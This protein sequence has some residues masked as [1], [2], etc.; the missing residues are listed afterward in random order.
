MVGVMA[1]S[2]AWSQTPG[3]LRQERDKLIER[4][5]WRDALTLYREK[6]AP[7]SDES[8]GPYLTMAVQSISRRRE[9]GTFD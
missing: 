5:L 1:I 6:L 7:V 2:S 4:G 3:E 8:S 9:W